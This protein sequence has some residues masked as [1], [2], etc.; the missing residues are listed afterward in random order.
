MTVMTMV[1]G[2]LPLVFASGAGANGNRA[3]GTGVVGGL[4]VGTSA[5]VFVVPL[6][7]IAFQFLQE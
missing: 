1:I 2:M 7:L 3:L 5:L 4:L 6:F